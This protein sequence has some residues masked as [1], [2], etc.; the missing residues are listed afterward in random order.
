MP[1][2]TKKKRTTSKKKRQKTSRATG[3][4]TST[5]KRT[6][7]K[8]APKKKR[9]A[10]R[11]AKQKK[12]AKSAPDTRRAEERKD[13]ALKILRALKRRYREANCALHH[14]NALELLV[15]TILSAQSTDANV[16]RVTPALF[17]RYQNATEFAAADLDELE[18]LIH[19]TGFFRQ[20]AK[21]IRAACQQIVET[22]GGEVPST[23]DELI[24]LPG[25]ARK[26]ANVILGTWFGQNDGVVV[27]THVGRIA[28]RL[29]LTWSSKDTKD[30]VK[31]EADLTEV[32]PRKH[33]TY[34]SHAVILHG[35][36]VCKAKKPLCDDCTLARHC[37]SAGAAE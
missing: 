30:A 28:W 13:R 3:G 2:S 6:T 12:R 4:E 25:V 32:L 9:P 37:P 11:Q 27:D 24:T 36:A 18:T 7:K 29:D 16:N 34:F 14:T 5:R 10:A 15:A 20:K 22:F 8:A 26:T 21:N 33:W 1:S 17:E 19:S 35:R 23:M 31:I